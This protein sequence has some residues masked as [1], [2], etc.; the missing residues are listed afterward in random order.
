MRRVWHVE[1]VLTRENHG[2]EGYEGYEVRL[3]VH[4]Y[5]PHVDFIEELR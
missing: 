2:S 5:R 1:A 4:D 3:S